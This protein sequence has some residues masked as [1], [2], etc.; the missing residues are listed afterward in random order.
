MEACMDD[1]LSTITAL[2]KSG[3]RLTLYRNT[4][5]LHWADLRRGWL[6]R[7]HVRVDLDRDEFEQ[8]KQI[9][10]IGLTRKR[11]RNARLK[12]VRGA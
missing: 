6:L 5:G 7:K 10:G 11:V 2:T 1:S 8:V 3:Y 12:R 4:L 9:L